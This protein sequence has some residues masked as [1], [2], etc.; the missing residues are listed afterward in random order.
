[1]NRKKEYPENLLE[2]LHANEVLRTELNYEQLSTDQRK[3][4]AFLFLCLSEREQILIRNYYMEQMSGKAIAA[5]YHLDESY[6]RSILDKALKKIGSKE[7]LLY[8]AEGY[9]VHTNNLYLQLMREEKRYCVLRGIKGFDSC[10]Y[11]HI[12]NLNLP[13]RIQ[14]EL[15]SASVLT[16]QEL[17]IKACIHS[18]FQRIRNLGAASRELIYTELKSRNLMPEG[19]HP[20][21]DIQRLPCINKIIF[22][23]KS[24][25]ESKS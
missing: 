3:G 6:T 16:V 4:I 7:H 9:E 20:L 2:A 5:R 22:V 13:V 1:M 12:R 11:G 17:L 19:Y 25:N 14:K 10:Y 24:L 21:E 23:Y 8:V 15:I 18:E